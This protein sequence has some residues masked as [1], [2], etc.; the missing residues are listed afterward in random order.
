MKPEQTKLNIGCGYR[1]LE[2]FWNVDKNPRVNPDEVLDLAKGP[3]P[4]EDDFFEKIH[5]EDCLNFIGADPDEFALVIQEMYR[6]SKHGAEWMVRTPHPRS[7]SVLDDFRQRRIITPRTLMMFDQKRN[8]E[9]LAKKMPEP[10]YGFDLGVDLEVKD[11]NY[12]LLPYWMEQQKNGMVGSTQIEINMMQ[13]NNVVDTI[14]FFLVVHKP[15]RFG[16]WFSTQ[17]KK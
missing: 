8:F 2:G 15:Q 3:W 6:V 17:T 12:N 5:A 13:Q 1:K 11:M 10:V 16:D 14:N 7:D 9:V 4:Y